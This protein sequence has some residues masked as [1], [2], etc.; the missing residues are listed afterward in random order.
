MHFEGKSPVFDPKDFKS[1]QEYNQ[2][3]GNHSVAHSNNS[4][5]HH[6]SSYVNLGKDA[7]RNYVNDLQDPS[8]YDSPRPL[9]PVTQKNNDTSCH[10]PLQS[11]TDSDSVFID[12]LIHHSNEIGQLKEIIE[13]GIH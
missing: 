3:Y 2:H 9:L 10:S 13:L 6:S 11:P 1:I 5:E 4:Y 8:F 7:D 12:D